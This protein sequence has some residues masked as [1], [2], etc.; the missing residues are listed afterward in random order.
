M[1]WGLNSEPAPYWIVTLAPSATIRIKG[2]RVTVAHACE[3]S[4]SGGRDQEDRGSKPAQGNSLRD[5]VL[6]NASPKKGW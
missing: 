2:S 5:P 3:P 6:K 4:D 1:V